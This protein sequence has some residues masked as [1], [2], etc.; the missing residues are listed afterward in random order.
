LQTLKGKVKCNALKIKGGSTNPLHTFFMTL[1][2]CSGISSVLECC[3][4]D[5]GPVFHMENSYLY[6]ENNLE[7][8]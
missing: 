4:G 5:L 8:N 2:S 7:R 6:K 1:L 3:I